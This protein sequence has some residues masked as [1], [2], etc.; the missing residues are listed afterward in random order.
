MPCSTSLYSSYTTPQTDY[1]RSLEELLA[2]AQ[3][4][5]GSSNARTGDRRPSDELVTY[6][7]YASGNIA[8][9]QGRLRSKETRERALVDAKKTNFD[10]RVLERRLELKQQWEGA[11]LNWLRPNDEPVRKAS[12]DD[13]ERRKRKVDL[14]Y[15]FTG[16]LNMTRQKQEL[17]GIAIALSLSRK[18]RK[19]DI[20][21]RIMTEI[22]ANLELKS[23]PRFQGLFNLRLQKR[24]RISKVL[25]AG[26]SQH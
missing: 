1:S 13:Q 3:G 24:A 9:L 5:T 19:R 10:P 8:C 16:P 26:P 17:E 14:S 7:Y 20:L 2:G 21:E 15:V 25:V 12:A 18:G 6:Y 23:D 4:R 22:G 11:M